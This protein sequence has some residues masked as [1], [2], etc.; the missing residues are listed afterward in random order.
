MF[1]I[2]NLSNEIKTLRYL[3]PVKVVIPGTPLYVSQRS[4]WTFM[5]W[6]RRKWE[7][8]RLKDSSNTN[9]YTHSEDGAIL[10]VFVDCLKKY[11]SFEYLMTY[12]FTDPVRFDLWNLLIS[13]DECWLLVVEYRVNNLT[14]CHLLGEIWYLEKKGSFSQLKNQDEKLLNSQAY[15]DKWTSLSWV[16]KRHIAYKRFFL[17]D[18]RGLRLC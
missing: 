9:S 18:Y 13:R 12:S 6:H 17:L 3:P 2:S 16:Y 5:R 10:I 8:P 15:V 4:T 11:S 7:K 14:I 1:Q